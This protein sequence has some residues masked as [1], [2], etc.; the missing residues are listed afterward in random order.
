MSEFS[1]YLTVSG[2]SVS[3]SSVK[4]SRFIGIAMPCTDE[5]KIRSNLKRVQTD[6]PNAT[7]YCY[8]A[9]FGGTNRSERS[10]DNGEPSGTAAKPILS[11]IRGNDL[12]DTM[13]VVVRYFGGTLLGTG[14]L[15]HAYTESAEASVKCTSIRRMHACSVFG[16]TLGYPDLN[17]FNS[18]CANLCAE[19]PKYTY[20]A[21]VGIEAAV[22]VGKAEEFLAAVSEATGRRAKIVPMGNGY[23]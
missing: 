13:I 14:G 23:R 20:E 7:H 17:P 19:P 11:V 3:E 5:E 16:I 22:P 21:S 18:K 15:V 9:I 10:S 2:I 12:T 8:A 4:G 1:D 6:F